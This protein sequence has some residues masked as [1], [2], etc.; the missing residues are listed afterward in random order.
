MRFGAWIHTGD[1]LSLASQV[2]A[3]SAVGIRSIRS[4]TLSYAE[5]AAPV[6]AA[7][8]MSL[9]AGMHIDAA[10]L[11]VDWRS[12]VRLDDLARY[13]AL[14]VPLDAICVGNEL[15]EG[16]DAPGQKRFTAR[17]SFGLANVLD[18]Y[19]R[20]L[21]NHGYDTPLTYAMES[22]VFD[23]EG[24]FYEWVW[25]L[26][27]ALDIVGLNAYPMGHEDWFTFGAFETSRAF[28]REDRA[29][30]D[31]MA[32]FEL[33]LRQ[34]LTQAASVDKP[35]ILTE[36]GFPSAVGYHIEDGKWVIPEH[37][38]AAYAMAMEEFLG[39]IRRINAE[40]DEAIR[41]LYFYEWRDNLQ[42]P[43][44]WNVEQSPIHVAFG[45]CDRSGTPKLDL[46][47]LLTG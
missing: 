36:T 39:C 24:T 26:I 42:H 3:A 33:R 10:A 31:R 27:D 30:H 38:V 11:M 47:R 16:G 17:L 37:D 22:I 28:V 12:Q 15:R 4:Y 20:W 35:V 34:A 14:G 5:L 43:K 6:L 40:Y 29:R 23:D 2:E 41:A 46:K 8:D 7:H 45:L 44:I 18:T 9:L 19:R 13:H 25:P 32:R 1:D 21:D